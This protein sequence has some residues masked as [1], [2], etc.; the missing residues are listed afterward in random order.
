MGEW[1]EVIHRVT[2]GVARRMR[3]WWLRRRGMTIGPDCWIQNVMVPRNAKDIKLGAGVALDRQVVLLATGEAIGAPRI[4]IGDN[5]Y[6]NRFTFIDATEYIEI[7]AG[8]MIGPHCYITDH[9]HG[10]AAHQ[11]LAEQDLVAEK[12]HIGRDVWIGAG[13]IILKGVT[14]G[15]Q[16]VVAAGAV[17]TKSVPERAMWLAFPLVSFER[18]RNVVMDTQTAPVSAI[19]PTWKRL[20]HLKETLQKLDA[21]DP[22]PAEII[23]HVDAGDTQT[24]PWLRENRSDVQVLTSNQQVGPGGG[25]N[26]LM[27][28]VQQPYVASLDDDSYPLEKLL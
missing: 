9:D 13:A 28:T 22:A 21:C 2:G 18:G 6:I 7:G 5:V 20:N 11:S 27:A 8:T 26:R 10:T 24:A 17:V 23:V 1:A 15:D 4:V 19:I 14:L 25:R 12:V 3:R 16:A